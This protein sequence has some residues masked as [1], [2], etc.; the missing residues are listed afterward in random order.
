MTHSIDENGQLLL[1]GVSAIRLARE[2]GTPLYVMEEQKIRA[3]MRLYT[4]ALKEGYAGRGLIC[5]A[6]KAF[7][8]K[9]IYRIAQIE[10]LGADVVSGGELYTAQ[11]AGF[12][13][14]NVCMHGNNKTKDEL[15][16]AI[17]AGIGRI[18]ADNPAELRLI[19]ELGIQLN[20]KV[21]VLLRVRP[22]I[23]AHTHA[24]IR[25]GQI[26][27]K[28]GTAIETGE[29]L[30]TVKFAFSLPNINFTGV[31]CHIGSQIF[32]ADPFVL[33]AETM[34][35][36]LAKIKKE[37]GVELR[38]LNLGGGFG[39]PYTDNDISE[40]TKNILYKIFDTVRRTAANHWIASPFLIFEPG[41]SI[42]AESGT[43]LY[44]V[45]ESKHI[46]GI[47]TYLPVDGGMCDNP[48]YILYGAKYEMA[49]ANKM[50]AERNKTYTVAGKCCE[51]GDLLGKKIPLQQAES[52]DVLAIFCTGAY[53]FSMFSNYNR[54]LRPAVV[55]VDGGKARLI[56]KRE[57]YEE[58]LR[59][60]I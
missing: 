21:R 12:D 27:S 3:S 6:S 30:E 45:G 43:T 34:V 28:F 9:E 52:G 31:H 17:N 16:A 13:L 22:G 46:P 24:F 48:R 7:C 58:L 39:I 32:C 5:Y 26:D 2:F 25:T 33:A 57:T 56:V 10:G 44:L 19:N 42:V 55:M 51:S 53:N 60:D 11:A 47:R 29:A 18:V 15:L 23:S 35:K 14:N 54:N 50:T 38:E 49:I 8:C 20:K 36:F 59:G 1:G 4:G 40:N 37:T 41:R